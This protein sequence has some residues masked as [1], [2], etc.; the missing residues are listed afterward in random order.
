MKTIKRSNKE[1]EALALPTLANLNP[2]SLYNKINKFQ[3]FVQSEDVDIVFLSKTWERQNKTL[4][5]IIDLEDYVVISNVYQREGVGGRPALI[6]NNKKYNVRN[7]TN[8]LVSVMC[9]V[10]AVW[11]II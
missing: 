8:T 10:E 11:A 6:V 4:S 5:E 2:R 7:I 9:G 3:E 1:L